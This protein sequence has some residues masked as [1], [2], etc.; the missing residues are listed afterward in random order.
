MHLAFVFAGRCPGA[1]STRGKLP[2][3]LASQ[4]DLGNNVEHCDLNRLDLGGMIWQPL[5]KNPRN[6][7][8]WY[9]VYSGRYLELTSFLHSRQS[10]FA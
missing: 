4:Y 2:S 10:F 9:D 1:S 6:G 8:R 3:A 5:Q 7:P